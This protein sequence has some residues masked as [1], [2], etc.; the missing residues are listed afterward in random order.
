MLLNG[1]Q[2]WQWFVIGVV[3]A[4]SEVFLP[5]AVLLWLGIAGMTMG[6]ITLI[7]SGLGWQAQLAL[8][9]VLSLLAL[10]VGLTLRRRF[11][12]IAK[13]R[14]VNLGTARLVGQRGALSTSIVD[15]RG[16]VRLGD[17]TW[18]VTGPDL[19]AGTSVTVTGTD[20][21]TLTVAPVADAPP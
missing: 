1:L 21:V 16:S 6:I 10:A 8:F 13:P 9:A 2:S 5:N 18:P 4:I 3:L 12:R 14:E 15:G 19:P 20:G 7:W 17:T 11:S